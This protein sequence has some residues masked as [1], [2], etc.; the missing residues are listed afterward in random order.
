M[1]YVTYDTLVQVVKYM[2]NES[3]YWFFGFGLVIGLMLVQLIWC[4]IR[5]KKL[6]KMVVK[7][8]VND[9]LIKTVI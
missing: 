9:G 7:R 3:C 4:T 6:E 8:G 2:I 1:N 5:L